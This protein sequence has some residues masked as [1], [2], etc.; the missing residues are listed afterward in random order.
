[1]TWSRA[2]RVFPCEPQPVEDTLSS[3]SLH[4]RNPPTGYLGFLPVVEMTRCVQTTGYQGWWSLEVFNKSLMDEDADC[5][6]RHG[7]RGIDGLNALWK[8]VADESWSGSEAS[9]NGTPP[10][11]LGAD[12]DEESESDESLTSF[13]GSEIVVKRELGRKEIGEEVRLE[14]WPESVA[15]RS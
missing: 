13:E 10:L 12:S 1:M 11:V 15:A 7:R 8:S 4:D 9:P 6:W 5:P 3:L 2:S 14:H